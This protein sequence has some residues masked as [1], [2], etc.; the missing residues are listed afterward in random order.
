MTD[1]V[2][3]HS[4]KS[5]Y[6]EAKIRSLPSDLNLEPK[7]RPSPVEADRTKA[8]LRGLEDCL[9]GNCDEISGEVGFTEGESNQRSASWS[10]SSWLFYREFVPGCS[11]LRLLPKPTASKWIL[12]SSFG[13]SVS[14]CGVTPPAG[15]HRPSHPS[16]LH[17]ATWRCCPVLV[18]MLSGFAGCNLPTTNSGARRKSPTPTRAPSP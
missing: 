15:Q 2:P 8:L 9:V 1:L 6:G 11:C 13:S 7:L 14:A 5:P 12:R 4:H 3:G 16:S 18:L 17:H 10:Q